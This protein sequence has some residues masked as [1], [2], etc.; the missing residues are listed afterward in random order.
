MIKTWQKIWPPPSEISEWFFWKS[1]FSKNRK[2][3]LFSRW[4]DFRGSIFEKTAESAGNRPESPPN[5]FGDKTTYFMGGRQKFLSGAPPAD[6]IPVLIKKTDLAFGFSDKIISR[7]C[8][9]FCQGGRALF[10][11]S[12]CRKRLSLTWD[13]VWT[14]GNPIWRS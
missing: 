14:D 1:R 12:I 3:R 10:F 11:L 5:I 9:N 7:G 2:K 13:K 6:F 4:R 8:R